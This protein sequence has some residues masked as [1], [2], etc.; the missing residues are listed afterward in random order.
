MSHAAWV[1]KR[2]YFENF[3]RHFA[4]F[5]STIDVDDQDLHWLSKSRNFHHYK[6]SNLLKLFENQVVGALCNIRILIL[7]GETP[8]WDVDAGR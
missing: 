2:K 1:N 7:G 5:Q 6:N 3:P 4:K 8:E